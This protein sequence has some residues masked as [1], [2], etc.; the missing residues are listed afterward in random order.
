MKR[1]MIF[2]SVLDFLELSLHLYTMSFYIH[3]PS[4]VSPLYYPHNRVSSFKTKLPER[5]KFEFNEYE[6]AATEFTYINR[7]KTFQQDTSRKIILLNPDIIN[8]ETDTYLI[9]NR[10]FENVEVLIN[11]INTSLTFSTGVYASFSY[12]KSLQRIKMKIKMGAFK[13]HE[14]LCRML[15]FTLTSYNGFCLFDESLTATNQPNLSASMSHIFV[16]CDIVKPQI[17]GDIFCPLLRII[18]ISMNKGET[19]TNEFRPN[20]LPLNR[21]EFDTIEI[22]LCNEFGEE[23]QFDHS[24]CIVT[25]HF[26]K[27]KNGN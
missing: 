12:E 11:E 16:Y 14:D 24:Q 5:F 21:L 25:L 9:S 20:Y 7:T 13:L 8:S 10:H 1:F 2:S 18:N 15:G 27:S 22:L 17:V 3:L 26:R 23:I 19:V 4:N 6:V